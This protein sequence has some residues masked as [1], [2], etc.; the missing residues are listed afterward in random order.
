M[1]Q[2]YKTHSDKINMVLSAILLYSAWH[3]GYE[4]FLAKNTTSSGIDWNLN[5]LLGYETAAWFSLFGYDAKVITYQ[6]YPHLMYL[7]NKPIISIDTP[8]NG[9][10]MLYLFASFVIAYPGTVKRKLTFITAGI[11]IIHV[12]NIIRIIVLSYISIYYA[13]Y[14]YFNHK[15]AFQIIVYTVVIAM[16]FYW[17]LYGNDPKTKWLAGIKDFICFR[18]IGRLNQLI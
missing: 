6:I 5:R 4:E 13:D 15:Y 16:W 18:F 2:F 1:L 9:L 7:D 11:L 12:L 8:C 10:P 3:F 14:F 17:V